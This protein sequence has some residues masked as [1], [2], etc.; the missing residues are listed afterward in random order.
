[1]LCVVLDENDKAFNYLEEAY[2][3]QDQWLH[4]VKVVSMF[5]AV[6]SDPRYQSLLQQMGLT[7][8]LI[9]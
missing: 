9:L 6:R 7:P 3:S 1:V 4:Y 2:V 8:E 5:D